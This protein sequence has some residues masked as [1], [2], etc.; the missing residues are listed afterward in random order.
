MGDR[1][2][3]VVVVRPG[4]PPVVEEIEGFDGARRVIGGIVQ[5]LP[6]GRWACLCDQDRV[7]KGLPPNR[8]VNGD[9]IHGPFVV[10]RLTPG[11]LEALSEAEAERFVRDLSE[12]GASGARDPA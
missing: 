10:T 11:D 9:M 3:R 6:V 1:D 4:M 7:A 8:R 5:Y 12:P 2:R